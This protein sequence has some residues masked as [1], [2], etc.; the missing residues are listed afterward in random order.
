M[1]EKYKKYLS[2]KIL[3]PSGIGLVLLVGIASAALG[4]GSGSNYDYTVAAKHDVEQIISV[5]GQ[6]KAA[7]D[8]DLAFEKS[9]KVAKVYFKVGDNVKS[10]QILVSLENASSAGQLSQAKAGV[11]SAEAQLKQYQATLDQQNA[12][13]NELKSGTRTET[14]NIDKTKITSA[15]NS[16]TDAQT[17][18]SNVENQAE[19]SLENLYLQIPDVL[20]SAYLYAE[21]ALNSETSAMTKDEDSQYPQLTF[22][23]TDYQIELDAGSKRKSAGEALNKFQNELASLPVDAE[24]L[25]AQMNNSIDELTTIRTFLSRLQDALGVSTLDSTTLATYQSNVKTA[26]TNVNTAISNINSQ[27]QSISAQIVLNENNVATAQAKVNEA[28][29]TLEA[30]KSQLLLDQAGPTSQEIA[31]QEAQVRSA[32]ANV[33]YQKSR[34]SEAKA[35]LSVTYADYVKAYLKAPFDGLVSKMDAKVGEIV[36][37][38]VVSMISQAKFELEASLPEAD[39]AKVKV[40]DKAKVTFDALG[41]DEIFDTTLSSIDPAEEVIDGVATYKIRLEFASD[42]T[43]LKSGMS[44]NI[45]IIGDKREG[46]IAVLARSIIK[47]D[48]ENYVRILNGEKVSEVKV[49]LGLRGT[50]GYVEIIDGIK[51]GDKV[52]NF[53]EE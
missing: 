40:G 20:Q 24:S 21:N 4:G 34:I 2:K 28:N 7:E 3:I 32:E 51:E 27:K 39:V 16:V 9:G 17:N 25:D 19:L 46:V 47:K 30:L 36:S 18:L 6:V 15:E 33:A 5:T 45:D 53:S 23:V 49:T 37:G 43:R 35:N 31:A 12:K 38:S 41:T 29:N 48:A 50:D 14:I 11:Q 52:I 1:M 10:G 8:V 44:A 26:W 13:L 22:G 42:D